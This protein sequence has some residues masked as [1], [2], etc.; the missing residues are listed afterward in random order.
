M[1]NGVQFLVNLR[2]KLSCFWPM[3]LEELYF[4]KF[5]WTTIFVEHLY[6]AAFVLWKAE[7]RSSLYEVFSMLQRSTQQLFLERPLIRSFLH[8]HR[9]PISNNF[10]K[11]FSAVSAMFSTLKNSLLRNSHY[12]SCVFFYWRFQQKNEI[13]KG[14]YPNGICLNDLFDVK[15][16]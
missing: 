8:N 16:V 5:C 12:K 10:P 9:L 15:D 11:I 13:E 1:K 6:K 7:A 3:V 4:I 14:K 2:V